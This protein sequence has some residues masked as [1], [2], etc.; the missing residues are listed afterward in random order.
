MTGIVQLPTSDFKNEAKQVPCLLWQKKMVKA[1]E[2]AMGVLKCV[3][4]CEGLD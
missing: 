4:V 2:A 3:S 1:N